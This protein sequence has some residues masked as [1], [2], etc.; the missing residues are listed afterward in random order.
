M[1]QYLQTRTDLFAAAVS[2]AGI[3]SITNYWGSGYW[4]MGYSTVAS[5]HSYPWSHRS[6]FVDRSPLFNAEKI[7]TPLLLL[8]GDSDTNV[9]TAESINMYNALKVLGREVELITFTGEDHFILEPERRIRW[10]ESIFAWFA[11]WLKD[12]PTWWKDLYESKE[13]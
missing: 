5:A 3:S 6:T 13:E 10:T 12:E 9:P 7:H 2:H 11:R 4:G 8:H 1:T